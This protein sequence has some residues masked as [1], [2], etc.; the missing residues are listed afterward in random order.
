ML[1]VLF[2]EHRFGIQNS[3]QKWAIILDRKLYIHLNSLKSN[4]KMSLVRL[5]ELVTVFKSWI[6]Y[7]CANLD[8]FWDCLI[9]L[10]AE[11]RVTY[12]FT[13]K[14]CTQHKLQT[15]MA[16][17]LETFK[18]TPRFWPRTPCFKAVQWNTSVLPKLRTNIETRICSCFLQRS[19][20][21]KEQ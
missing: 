17:D 9:P 14:Y 11:T 19:R 2:Y 3:K 8:D 21:Y 5:I 6:A 4:I 15:I 12:I 18:R 1:T 7:V 16:T 20:I 10:S 13:K